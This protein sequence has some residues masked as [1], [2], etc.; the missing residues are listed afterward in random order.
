M[1]GESVKLKTLDIWRVSLECD[2]HE[3]AI[4]VVA[5][6]YKEAIK[7]AKKVLEK[8]HG[9]SYCDP[10]VTEVS[11]IDSEVWIKEV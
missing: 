7:I 5:K 3:Y 9:Y 8:E 11:L 6:D 2:D 1:G 4:E 10:R